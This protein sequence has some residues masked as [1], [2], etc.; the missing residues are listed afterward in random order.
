MLFANERLKKAKYEK[1]ELEVARSVPY[2]VHVYVR[3]SSV[4]VSKKKLNVA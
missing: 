4:K 3:F 2:D 1:I